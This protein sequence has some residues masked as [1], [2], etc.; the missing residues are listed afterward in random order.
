MKKKKVVI[1]GGGM[2]GLTAGAYINKKKCD[3]VLLE[4]N[5]NTGGLVQTYERNGFFFDS[6][7]RAFI[8]S[9]MVKPIFRDLGL[10]FEEIENKISFLIEDE[11]FCIDN[12]QSLVAYKNCLHRLY[13]ENKTDVDIIINKIQELS[14]DNYVLYQYDNP[15]FA[16]YFSDLKFMATKFIPWS[17]KLLFVLRKFKKYQMPMEEYL[18][19]ITKNK[20]L[21]DILTQFFFRETP[22][23][24][25]LGYYCVWLDY[26]YT[27]SGTGILPKLLEQKNIKDGTKILTN[28]TVDTVHVKEKFVLDTKGNK[29]EY[30]NLIWAAD[31]KNLYEKC[32]LVGLSDKISNQIEKKS[33]EIREAKPAESSFVVHIAVD[34]PPS[35]FSDI[36]GCHSFYTHSKK[37]LGE[38]NKTQKD[39]LLEKFDTV[40]KKDIL[41][42]LDDF[43]T[44]NTYEVS[45]PVLR[46]STLA[47]PGK[48]GIMISCLFDYEIIEKVEDAG[49]IKEFKKEFEQRIIAIFSESVFKDFKEDILFHF[50]STPLTIKRYVDSS[51]GSMVGW[52]FETKS[53]VYNQL[54]DMLKST[55][56]S[57]PHVYQS[58][59]WSYAPA[60]VPIAMSTGWLA[61][62]KI[63]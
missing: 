27:K 61:S 54:P 28:V 6:G 11:K 13:P 26:F 20:S 30:D 4:K 10:E 40:S 29:Y 63:L 23:Y 62:K 59:Q 57:I 14:K 42:W 41:S 34:R 48:T 17:I 7:P 53:P 19:T 16:D 3:V 32:N 60:G 50:S 25:A 38:I 56:T 51:H 52:S 9:G 37:G 35:Y 47:P 15:F 2:S 46:D 33:F 22:T 39:S 31:L 12:M 24:F 43:C 1:V 21:I 45:I 58:G 18:S 5:S 36:C 8:N 44:Y 49:W 55:Q